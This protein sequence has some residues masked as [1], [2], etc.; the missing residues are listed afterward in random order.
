MTTITP[1]K[2]YFFL[3]FFFLFFHL[4]H[5]SIIAKNTA[6]GL[7]G[8]NTENSRFTVQRFFFHYANG[9]TARCNFA[10]SWRVLN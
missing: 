1:W 6:T 3:A 7:G 5:Y 10:E 4:L 9:A 8:V 2:T